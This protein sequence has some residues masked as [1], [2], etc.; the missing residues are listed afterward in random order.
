MTVVRAFVA[1]NLIDGL[2]PTSD[3]LRAAPEI[4]ATV[5]AGA[6]ELGT[7]P[8]VALSADLHGHLVDVAYYWLGQTRLFGR[9]SSQSQDPPQCPF[10]RD[11]GIA[12]CAQLRERAIAERAIGVAKVLDAVRRSSCAAA[13]SRTCA[14]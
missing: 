13:A 11:H 4:G 10:A 6:R 7:R 12:L 8:G 5:I 3:E 2:Y 1:A 14:G 9:T